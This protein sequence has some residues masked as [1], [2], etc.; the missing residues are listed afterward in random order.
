MILYGELSVNNSEG[1]Q[2]HE[3]KSKKFAT[4][5]KEKMQPLIASPTISPLRLLYGWASFTIPAK[6]VEFRTHCK[7]NKYH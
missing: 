2:T 5:P 3:Q 4:L 6:L 1:Y 7:S